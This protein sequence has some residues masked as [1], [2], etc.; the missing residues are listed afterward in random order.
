MNWYIAMPS[1]DSKQQARFRYATQQ[2]D[3]VPRQL[4]GQ[5]GMF[6]DRA[7]ENYPRFSHRRGDDLGVVNFLRA[8]LMKKISFRTPGFQGC[9][10]GWGG[11]GLIEKA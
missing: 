6:F 9:F 4:R 2:P 10:H 8:T 3:L 7:P 11:N 1:L 5:L